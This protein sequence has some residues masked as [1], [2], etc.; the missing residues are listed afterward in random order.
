MVAIFAFAL[1]LLPLVSFAQEFVPLVGIPFMDTP[2]DDT[3]LG[4][5]AQAFYIAAISLGA[6]I[7]VLKIIFA[8]VKYMLTDVVTDKSQAKSDIKGALLGL[9]LIIGAVLILETISPDIT[10]LRA[11]NL[12]ALRIEPPVAPPVSPADQCADGLDYEVTNEN[13]DG[14]C[15]DNSLPEIDQ[16]FRDNPDAGRAF[17][18]S[19]GDP[20][21]LYNPTTNS[22]VRVEEVNRLPDEIIDELW[23]RSGEDPA[24]YQQEGNFQCAGMYPDSTPY[25]DP[26]NRS[27]VAGNA[28]SIN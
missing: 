26:V 4:D 3:T 5:Y 27:C 1:L 18:Q 14:I 22:C 17:C 12:T 24:F 20:N 13:P 6:V 25:F 8:G 21:M 15:V 16:D 9:I 7:A 19:N 23:L 10:S 2:T 28:A 11:F